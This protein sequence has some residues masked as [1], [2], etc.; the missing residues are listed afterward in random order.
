MAFKK[1]HKDSIKLLVSQILA[2]E[3]AA[4]LGGPPRTIDDIEN[5][6]V[7]IG[8]SVAREIGRQL[9]TDCTAE[10]PE[11]P[12]CPKCG[13]AGKPCGEKT[14]DIITRRGNVEVTEAKFNCPKCRQLFFPSDRRIGA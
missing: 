9:L 8:D 3:K 11:S 7:D 1:S 14:R 5:A 6:M 4:G 2:A 13:T 12:P 10:V